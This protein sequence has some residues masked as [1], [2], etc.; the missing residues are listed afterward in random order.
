MCSRRS[1]RPGRV[2]CVGLPGAFCCAALFLL[3]FRSSFW[4]PL[5]CA[6]PHFCL[7]YRAPLV[8]AFL[9]FR[10]LGALGLGALLLPPTPPLLSIFFAPPLYPVASGS[11][12]LVPLGWPSFPSLA[13]RP[14][15]VLRGGAVFPCCAPPP[16]PGPGLMWFRSGVP[17]IFMG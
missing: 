4:P 7:F 1:G 5:G 17:W 16:H 3:L 8:S 12:P 13:L 6:C 14:C 10:A 2:G 9:L 15:V 11:R